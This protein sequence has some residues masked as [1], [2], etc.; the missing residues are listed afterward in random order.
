VGERLEWE[1]DAEQRV[2]SRDPYRFNAKR[3]V[4]TG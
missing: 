1:P 3:L 2:A 4:P